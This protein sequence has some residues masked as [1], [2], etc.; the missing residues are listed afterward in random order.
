MSEISAQW[1]VVLFQ[2]LIALGLLNVWL[3]RSGRA[4]KYRGGSAR[5]MKEEFATYGLPTWFMYVVGFLKVV[6]A[7]IMIVGLFMP[8]V[9]YSI[10]LVA[11]ALLAVLMLGAVSMHLKVHDPVVKMLPAFSMLTMAIVIIVL[12]L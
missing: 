5:N 12:V 6:I 11:L 10:G 4:T 7:A 8:Y 3:V 2:V 1:V 9:M